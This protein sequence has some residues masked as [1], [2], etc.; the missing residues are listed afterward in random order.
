MDSSLNTS[1]ISNNVYRYCPFVNFTHNF[2]FMVFIVFGLS[3]PNVTNLISCSFSTLRFSFSTNF[4]LYKFSG[5]QNLRAVLF[6]LY[7]N[8]LNFTCVDA[9]CI[10][11]ISFEEIR[12]FSS[13]FSNL[14]IFLRKNKCLLYL[15]CI[16]G[17]QTSTV[18]ITF[19][20]IYAGFVYHTV[21]GD[22][23]ILNTD[24]TDV[25]FFPLEFSKI[26]PFVAPVSFPTIST[27]IVVSSLYW[28]IICTCCKGFC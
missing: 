27:L 9:I 4:P 25:A 5:I 12:T 22:V 26:R 21:V 16:L 7:E 24:E 15:I 1:S 14:P 10:R 18:S 13:S 11:T 28:N 8:C 6:V 20:S 19:S 23:S 2:V 3:L 17:T